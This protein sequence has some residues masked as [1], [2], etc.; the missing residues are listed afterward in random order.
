MSRNLHL[1]GVKLAVPLLVAGIVANLVESAAVPHTFDN[2]AIEVIGVQ[3]SAAA[4]LLSNLGQTVLLVEALEG[5]LAVCA[6]VLVYPHGHVA[7][8]VKAFVAVI[9]NNG[10]HQP[11]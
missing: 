9:G 1:D 6:H 7:V 2:G 10:S 8:F 3:E 4:G 11:A 5:F